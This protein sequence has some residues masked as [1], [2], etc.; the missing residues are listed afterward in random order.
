MM[1]MMRAMVV[2]SVG[3]SASFA[4]KRRMMSNVVV[5]TKFALHY[6]YVDDILEKRD[7]FR[8]NHIALARR[9]KASGDLIMGGAYAD[10]VDGAL[11]LF[12]SLSAA[13]KFVAEDPYVSNN[14][15]VDHWIREWSTV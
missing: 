3:S 7:A 11:V 6:T 2:K 14:L 9:M 8:E 4:V 5:E 1:M 13:E 10:P 15:V 12:N